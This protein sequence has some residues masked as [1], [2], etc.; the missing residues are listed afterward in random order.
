MSR[1]GSGS[2]AD[3]NK[4][5]ILAVLRA[6]VGT[7]HRLQ[8]LEVASGC[9]LH[10]AHFAQALPNLEWQPSEVDPQALAR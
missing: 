4:E 5:P 7:G 3:R 2:A 1:Q 6:Y 10:A 8:V 9:G